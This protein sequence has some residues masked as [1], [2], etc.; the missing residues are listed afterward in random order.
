MT[1]PDIPGI[2]V[3]TDKRQDIT[4]TVTAAIAAAL[5]VPKAFFKLHFR[6]SG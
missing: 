3:R 2:Q 4:P 6:F 5:E 1:V